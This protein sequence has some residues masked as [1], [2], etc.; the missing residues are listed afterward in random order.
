MYKRECHIKDHIFR[1]QGTKQ[2][3]TTHLT[4]S[5]ISG[6]QQTMIW[7]GRADLGP[8]DGFGE[9]GRTCSYLGIW[10]GGRTDLG[11]ADGR[12]WAG[13]TDGFGEDGR[14]DE[15]PAR[16]SPGGRAEIREGSEGRLTGGRRTADGRTT[17]GRPADRRT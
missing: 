14:T 7:G 12:I 8:T 1:L 17:D 5:A 4:S 10:D 15:R 16:F 3:S 2:P 6:V 13:R 9:D 11:L